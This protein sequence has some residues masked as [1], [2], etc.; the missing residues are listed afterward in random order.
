M[1]GHRQELNVGRRW[2]W[3]QIPGPGLCNRCLKRADSTRNR[4]LP[5]SLEFQDSTFSFHTGS[6]GVSNEQQSQ[7]LSV[8][9]GWGS[10]NGSRPWPRGR[11]LAH[12]RDLALLIGCLL[13]LPAVWTPGGHDVL[14]M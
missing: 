5:A 1:I 12:R 9:R 10:P 13:Q 3:R 2:E 7:D 8:L 6:A 11:S 4:D 14:G